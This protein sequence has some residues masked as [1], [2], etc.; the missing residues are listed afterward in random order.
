MNASFSFIFQAKGAKK[1][2]RNFSSTKGVFTPKSL[3]NVSVIKYNPLELG[4][5]LL[6]YDRIGFSSN[7]SQ[8]KTFS[9]N[10]ESW[11]KKSLK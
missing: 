4:P 2:E 1:V 8:Q 6:F 11:K 5:L 9:I 3:T 7:A 10:N